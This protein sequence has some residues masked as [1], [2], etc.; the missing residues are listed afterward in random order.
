MSRAGPRLARSTV[1]A[2]FNVL[3]IAVVLGYSA[4][5]TAHVVSVSQGDLVLD[6]TTAQFELRMP[7][8]EAPEGPRRDQLLLEAFDVRVDGRSVERGTG[9]CREASSGADLICRTELRFDT[10]PTTVSVRSDLPSVTVP[11]HVH[12][13]RSGEGDMARQ[14][15]LDITVREASVRFAPPTT[16]EIVQTASGAGMRRVLTNPEL[17]LF[18]IAL[19]LAGRTLRELSACMGGFLC[20]Q[21]LVVATAGIHGWLP[22]LGFLESAAALAVAYLAAEVLALPEGTHRWVVCA[23]IGCFHGL[24][25][26]SFVASAE[27]PVQYFLP[28][29]LGAE[30]ALAAVAGT[31]RLRFANQ[32]S[33]QIVAILLLVIGLGWFGLRLIG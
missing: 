30:G 27:L 28:A 20:V 18:L 7:L 29:A 15:V 8:S 33:E 31:I 3:A 23:L 2:T 22:P 11:Q 16:L 26:A 14:T 32:R 4:P 1:G 12:V 6:G 24:F 17:L 21:A 5:M 19:A 13:L 25:L 9:S 10:E